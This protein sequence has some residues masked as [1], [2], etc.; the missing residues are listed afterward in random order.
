[1]YVEFYAGFTTSLLYR[2]TADYRSYDVDDASLIPSMSV[3][4]TRINKGRVV[5]NAYYNALYYFRTLVAY[6]DSQ[7]KSCVLFR[8]TYGLRLWMEN[9]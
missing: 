1:M 3:M 7:R 5:R 8:C 9:L 2:T 4:A 6:M